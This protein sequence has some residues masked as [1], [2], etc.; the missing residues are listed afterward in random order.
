[1]KKILLSENVM[2]SDPCYEDPTWCQAKLSNVL[3]GY[4]N[5]YCK[6]TDSG[7]WG[8]RNSMLLVIHEDYDGKLLDW[9]ETPYDIGVDSGQAGIFNLPT[10]RNDAHSV[11]QEHP[12]PSKVPGCS[13]EYG[14][15]GDEPGEKFYDLMCGIT[16]NNED[17]CGVYDQ[18][19]VSRSGYGDGGYKLY[20]AKDNGNIIGMCIDFGVDEDE[21]IDFE[22]YTDSMNKV[23]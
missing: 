4:Y 23:V 19:V 1:M 20:I 2:V 6:I 7:D 8:E 18:G 13:W 10:Y 21:V 17:G 11:L 9:E 12:E 15:F 3:P 22:F 5:P 14:R 16:L